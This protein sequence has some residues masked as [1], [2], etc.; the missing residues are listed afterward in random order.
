MLIMT[1]PL[2]QPI[3]LQGLLVASDGT[4]I[5]VPV[6]CQY[7]QYIFQSFYYFVF[8]QTARI[9]RLMQIHI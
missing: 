5:S 7:R 1:S 9:E 2:L 8:G 3:S 4:V 6:V